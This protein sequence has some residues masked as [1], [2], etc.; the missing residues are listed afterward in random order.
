M[1]V[2]H[3]YT[4]MLPWIRLANSLDKNCHRKVTVFYNDKEEEYIA[5]PY[6]IKNEK[7]DYYEV[8]CKLDE[9]CSVIKYLSP[10][11]ITKIEKF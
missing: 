5:Y 10:E 1:S 8:Y 9:S 4:D 11:Y 3:L 6:P 2:E 7:G